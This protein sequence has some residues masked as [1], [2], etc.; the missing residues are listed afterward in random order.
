[1]PDYEIIRWDRNKFSIE[2][3]PFV[4]EAY[5]VKKWAFASDYIRLYAL[6]NEGGIYLDSDV[7]VRSK[8]VEAATL[9]GKLA[10]KSMG[11][12]GDFFWALGRSCCKVK[13]L[14]KDG[15]CDKDPCTLRILLKS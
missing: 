15:S 10:D 14:C 5:S 3:V 2:S 4:N 8:A 9:L 12:I 7:L 6:Y 1:M 11:Q 13:R